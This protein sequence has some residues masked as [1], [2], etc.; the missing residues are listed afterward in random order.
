MLG[1]DLESKETGDLFI[2]V[3]ARQKALAHARPSLGRAT[4]ACVHVVPESRP[5][6]NCRRMA[7]AD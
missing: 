2:E 4:G 1:V 3:L 7:L 6:W 5:A